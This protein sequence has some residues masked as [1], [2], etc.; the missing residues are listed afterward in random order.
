MVTWSGCSVKDSVAVV[1]DHDNGDRVIATVLKLRLCVYTYVH[2]VRAR[3]AHV[4]SHV[5]TGGAKG[6]PLGGG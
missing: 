3:H 4:K 5:G 2:A 1:D 6:G